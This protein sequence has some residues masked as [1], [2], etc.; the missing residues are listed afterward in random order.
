M[1]RGSLTLL[2][3]ADR[4]EGWRETTQGGTVASGL[5][6]KHVATAGCLSWGRLGHFL[7]TPEICVLSAELNLNFPI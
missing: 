4:R 1:G 2:F 7:L 5:W 6:A 3:P